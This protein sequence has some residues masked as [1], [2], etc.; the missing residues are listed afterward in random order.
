[1]YGGVREQIAQILCIFP[2]PCRKELGRCSGGSAPS[3][4]A[5]WVSS[6]GPVICHDSAKYGTSDHPGAISHLLAVSCSTRL[7]DE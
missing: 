3:D 1:M 6:G 5:P 4:L 7:H 2:W